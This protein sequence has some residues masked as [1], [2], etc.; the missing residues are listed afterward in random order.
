M[1]TLKRSIS[2]LILFTANAQAFIAPYTPLKSL[3]TITTVSSYV[4]KSPYCPNC[5]QS[6]SCVYSLN[7]FRIA[8]KIPSRWPFF[9]PQSSFTAVD[10]CVAAFTILL[11]SFIGM[12]SERKKL[13]GGDAGTVLALT[14]AALMSNLGIFG[15]EVP[16][17]H[18]I[19]D[20]C[21]TRLLPSSLA[22]F[23]MSYSNSIDDPMQRRT[24]TG[25]N[26]H[27][28]NSSTNNS[29]GD[30]I[31]RQWTVIACGI[32]FIIGSI[33]SALGCFCSAF[34]MARFSSCMPTLFRMQPYEA[35]VAAGT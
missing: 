6:C 3:K 16:T 28:G 19:Y 7:P 2:V 14:S 24:S 35:A 20:I 15:L 25:S 23:L 18:P 12:M 1:I 29:Y 5:P 10:S 13:F 31:R 17:H 4:Q 30:N 22:L 21:W 34:I 11:S 9:R 8:T 32:P 33:G 27:E 26:G